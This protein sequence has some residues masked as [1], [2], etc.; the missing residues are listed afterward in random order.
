MD[1]QRLDTLITTS[2]P[3]EMAQP[4]TLMA[5]ITHYYRFILAIIQCGIVLTTFIVAASKYKT[6]STLLYPC[7]ITILYIIVYIIR[8]LPFG[9][10]LG[11]HKWWIAQIFAGW[12]EIVLLT[13]LN[14]SYA[15]CETMHISYWWALYLLPVFRLA[16]IGGFGGWLLG[17]IFSSIGIILEILFYQSLEEIVNWSSSISRIALLTLNTFIPYYI[18]RLLTLRRQSTQFWHPLI[19]RSVKSVSEG[20]DLLQKLFYEGMNDLINADWGVLW[21][22]DVRDSEFVLQA[23][24]KYKR[25]ILTHPFWQKRLEHRDGMIVMGEEIIPAEAILYARNEMLSRKD[26]I[27]NSKEGP[28]LILAQDEMNYQHIIPVYI[29]KTD[30][31]IGFLEVGLQHAPKK[32]AFPGVEITVEAEVEARST[33]TAEGLGLIFSDIQQIQAN[34]LREK[35]IEIEQEATD[36]ATMYE[37]SV[38]AMEDYFHRPVLLIDYSTKYGRIQTITGQLEATKVNELEQTLNAQ[39][40]QSTQ[41]DEIS[42]CQLPAAQQGQEC[43]FVCLVDVRKTTLEFL[44]LIDIFD[45]LSAD[46]Q[47]VMCNCAR[48]VNISTARK[49]AINLIQNDTSA[50]LGAL[51]NRNRLRKLAQ[52]VR[53]D[54]LADVVV[55]Y[56]FENGKP[57][58]PPIIEGD[59]KKPDYLVE[60]PIVI[61]DPNPILKVSRADAPLFF[62]NILSHPMSKGRNRHGDDVFVV[63]EGILSSVGIPLKTEHNVVGVMW[64]NF[65]ILQT[66]DKARQTYYQELFKQLPHRL[67]SLK[68]VETIQ[69]LAEKRARDHLR[70]ELHDHILQDIIAAGAFTSTAMAKLPEQANESSEDLVRAL[71]TLE[72]AE[73]KTR[74]ILDDLQEISQD[75]DIARQLNGLTQ[76]LQEEFGFP[77]DLRT[78]GLKEIPPIL[79]EELYPVVEE[80]I[81]N[82]AKHGKASR[83][84]VQASNADNALMLIIRDNGNGFE[85]K[86]ENFSHGISLMQSRVHWLKGKMQITSKKNEGTSIVIEVPILA[87]D[88][89]L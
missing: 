14:I 8:L 4:T 53:E 27:E 36:I 82:A 56:E 84:I 35:L 59:L 76:R 32:R 15:R 77:A 85:P 48:T 41:L 88:N 25:D 52:R 70:G 34:L 24:Y 54:I 40:Y 69:S 64:I 80:A 60:R 22:L 61:E 21:E 3:H 46:E 31:P 37:L 68:F 1:E 12:L 17:I 9:N 2:K 81:R 33:A 73:K 11:P 23:L 67:E 50:D 78:D 45:H 75:L 66:F 44:V 55:L 10:R 74:M 63:R 79:Y 7:I 20:Y 13:T 51:A 5:L 87:G 43:Y 49:R 47:Q 65:R 89:L 86:H 57:K 18:F 30:R 83:V 29:K 62:S 72:D 28:W 19:S 6:N 58:L 26:I 42:V 16:E 38:R 39:K 71:S